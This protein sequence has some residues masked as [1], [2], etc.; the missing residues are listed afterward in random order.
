[1]A[2]KSLS[3]EQQEKLSRIL[4]VETK[5]PI[6]QPTGSSV[7]VPPSYQVTDL[8]GTNPNTKVVMNTAP[9]VTTVV[10][11]E[12]PAEQRKSSLL[13]LLFIIGGIILLGAYT[14]FWLKFFGIPFFGL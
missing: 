14:F 8:Q 6:A 11:P 10:G 9:T 12:K 1:M 13:P 5:S 3:P 7:P 2:D 4:S